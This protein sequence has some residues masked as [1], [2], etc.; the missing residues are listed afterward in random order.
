MELPHRYT[1]LKLIGYGAQ[2][3]VVSAVDSK[4]SKQVAIKKLICA[5]KDELHAKRSYREFDLMSRVNHRNVIKLLS[6]Y[7]P[8]S[9]LHE[10]KD[11]YLVMEL[12]DNNL[13]AVVKM[14]KGEMDHERLSYLLYQL[15]CGIHHLH[16]SGIIHRD[17]K[18]TNIAVRYEECEL[19]ILDFGLARSANGGLMKSPY[20]VTRPYRAPEII[21]GA[22]NYTHGNGVTEYDTQADVWSTGCIF[23]E[24]FRG[25]VLFL[26]E[27]QLQQWGRITQVLGK[28]DATF[29][30]R[31][32][33]TVRELVERHP[34]WPPMPW[35]RLFPDGQIRELA[36]SPEATNEN[37]R[38]LLSK[39]LVIDPMRRITVEEALRH[40]YVKQWSAEVDG[41]GSGQYD[42][43][44]E[45]QNLTVEQWM[46][47]SAPLLQLVF[48]EEEHFAAK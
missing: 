3:I 32:Q 8:Q 25:E 38:D 30:S 6:A 22:V 42:A 36:T 33:P 31:L 13:D 19:K 10:F 35:A 27:N 15:L 21:L 9:S 23:A 47:K 26:A 12:M 29:T 43:A 28:P 48:G 14:E 18:P 44:I 7:T 17:L 4:T 41:P 5:F 20:V 16:K 24:L 39:M 1:H 2:G 37:A 34:S 45:G 11:I 46:G 40:P